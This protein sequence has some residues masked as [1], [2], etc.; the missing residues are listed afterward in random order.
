MSTLSL[1]VALLLAFVGVVALYL[2]LRRIRLESLRVGS[3][4]VALSTPIDFG[5]RELGLPTA[6]VG[7]LCLVGLLQLGGWLTRLT[8]GPAITTDSVAR[9]AIVN[10]DEDEGLTVI[11]VR[12]PDTMAAWKVL[13]DAADVAVEV[14]ATVRVGPPA[15]VS[16]I[17]FRAAGDEPQPGLSV[18]TSAG[19]EWPES[20]YLFCASHATSKW[21]LSS[22][23][24]GEMALIAPFADSNA[25]ESGTS[26][27]LGVRAVGDQITVTING[28]E[29]GVF[30]DATS[31]SGAVHLVCGSPVETRPTAI[32]HFAD[33]S[34]ETLD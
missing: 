10:T 28:Q 34:V 31:I 14:D 4:R 32:C 12:E 2:P 8:E 7:L 21:A 29:V 17:A 13:P 27:R 16:C 26:N 23:V 5:R 30:T 1:P 20:G 6:L 15:S 25:F 3:R 22:F 19:A 9:Y 11:R 24:D 33:L 18:R